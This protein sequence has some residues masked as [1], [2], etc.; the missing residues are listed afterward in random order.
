MRELDIFQA[1]QR[2][3]DQSET[4]WLC[5][6][7]ATW[8]SSPRPVGSLLACNGKGEFIGSL[9]GGCVEE[10]LLARIVGG[11]FSRSFTQ[12]QYG[13]THEESEKFRLP[14]GGILDVAIEK[15]QYCSSTLTSIASII[16]ALEQRQR[17]VWQSDS[18][19]VR[20]VLG[21]QYRL[22]LIG[23]SEVS[24]AVA[25]LALLLDYEIL[26]C[27][28]RA[29]ARMRWDIAGVTLLTQL[30]DDAVREYGDD[31]QCAILA[32]T[33]DPRIDDMAL[34]EA[35]NTQAFYIG[36]M[37]S[38]QTS[39]KRRERLLQLDVTEQQQQRLHAPIGLDIGSKT[40]MEIAI[41]IL[42]QLTAVRS[43]KTG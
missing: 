6:V 11:E 37:G 41:S 23:V 1:I 38:L 30:P 8:G 9:S 27:D 7:L 40:P 22:L 33:H 26:V 3:L 18:S 25:Q 21:P 10:D 36:A 17:I 20:H 34:M 2:W 28:P 29:D 42:S 4:V 5:T 13:S 39:K 24:R 14:C 32:L 12:I 35:F 31:V 19:S 16:S 15:L 43:G